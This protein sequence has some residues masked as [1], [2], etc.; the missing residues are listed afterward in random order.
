MVTF[1]FQGLSF[2]FLEIYVLKSQE[3]G[4]QSLTGQLVS[5]LGNGIYFKGAVIPLFY[6]FLGINI[7]RPGAGVLGLRGQC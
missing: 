4:C 6:L 5:C 2:V 7:E 1:I 3:A